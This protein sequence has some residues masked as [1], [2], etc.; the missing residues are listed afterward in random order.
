MVNTNNQIVY[1]YYCDESC[2]LLNDR[3]EFMVLGYVSVKYSYIRK[4]KYKIKELRK[5]HKNI[6]EVKWTKLNAWNYK[7]YAD[8]IDMFFEHAFMSFRAI[9]INKTRYLGEK[10]DNDYDKFYFKSSN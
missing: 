6:Y 4:I 3:K 8:L 1:N 10:C 7:F 5:K 2:H 9:I